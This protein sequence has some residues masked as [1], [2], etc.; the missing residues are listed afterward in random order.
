MA[1]YRLE[2]EGHSYARIDALS[3][4]V[5]VAKS[6]SDAAIEEYMNGTLDAVGSDPTTLSLSL[7]LHTVPNAKQRHRMAAIINERGHPEILRAA[8]LT[9]SVLYRAAITALGW[10]TRLHA[11]AFA[12]D[13]YPSALRWLRA[14]DGFDVDE[15]STVLVD[16]LR[17]AGIDAPPPPTGPRTAGTSSPDGS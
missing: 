13:D 7:F 8:L 15:A 4:N 11:A 17:R 1:N 10:L 3:I 5:C 16:M 14:A 6:L 2:F 12:I 9:D